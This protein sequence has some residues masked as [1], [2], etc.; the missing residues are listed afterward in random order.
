M[1]LLSSCGAQETELCLQE[2]SFRQVSGT[3]L[4]TESPINNIFFPLSVSRNRSCCCGSGV[5]VNGQV[6][7]G[8]SD[9][10]AWGS[11]KPNTS[12]HSPQIIVEDDAGLPKR[13]YHIVSRVICRTRLP[14][15]LLHCN[16][17]EMD[18]MLHRGTDCV[19]ACVC[20]F[21]V[22]SL[23]IPVL[24][25]HVFCTCSGHA[26]EIV[27]HEIHTKSCVAGSHGAVKPLQGLVHEARGFRS[28]A[29]VCYVRPTNQEWQCW[30]Y[31][32]QGIPLCLRARP[33]TYGIPEPGTLQ[34]SAG[35]AETWSSFAVP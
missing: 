21:C 20:S 7:T 13:I 1:S 28:G 19:C 31:R 5:L 15:A 22:C 23:C 9:A 16:T 6:K 32:T 17:A 26:F 8:N 29:F 10:Q 3:N 27:A 2:R 12:A 18:T 25:K 30:G 11:H 24:E 14:V 34:C 35:P 4:V 33:P